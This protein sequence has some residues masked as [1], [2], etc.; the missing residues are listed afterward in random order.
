MWVHMCLQRCIAAIACLK[1]ALY[2][3]PFDW[4]VAYNLGLVGKDL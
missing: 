1:K 4:I 3:G 2:L